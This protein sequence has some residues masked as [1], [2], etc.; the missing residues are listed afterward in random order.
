MH[1]Q[2]LT[3]FLEQRV[4]KNDIFVPAM[5][6]YLVRNNGKGTIE[7]ISRLIYIFDHKQELAYYDTIVE[8]FAGVL[9]E[10]YNIIHKEEDTYTL[11][12]WPLSSEEIH[13]I[14]LACSKKANGFFTPSTENYQRR[15]LSA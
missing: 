2:H 11:H 4:R 14:T 3:N 10:E 15:E 7:E 13:A 5:L 6:L 1:Y 12:T 8:K 9:L